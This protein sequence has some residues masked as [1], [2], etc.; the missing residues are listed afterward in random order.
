MRFEPM[1]VRFQ[2]QP[3]PI[4]LPSVNSSMARLTS[5]SMTRLSLQ[6]INLELG[7]IGDIRKATPNGRN[8]SQ[9]PPTGRASVKPGPTHSMNPHRT[10]VLCRSCARYAVM[11]GSK[12]QPCPVRRS[13]SHQ[14]TENQHDKSPIK[15]QKAPPGLAS[16]C[17]F[18]VWSPL[19][20]VSTS[21]PH[22][23]SSDGCLAHFC[24]T[25]D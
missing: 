8:S 15:V 21:E 2:P 18:P 23:G 17:C 25:S 10:L 5:S 3:F 7:G 6:S 1:L 24:I 13:V 4:T 19:E 11:R 22:P 9:K 12:T 16:H 14:A 20:C